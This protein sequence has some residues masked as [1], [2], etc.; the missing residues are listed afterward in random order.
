MQLMSVG[1]TTL[2]CDAFDESGKIIS[3]EHRRKRGSPPAP[4]ASAQR[5]R[6][7]VE[8]A[9]ERTRGVLW[10]NTNFRTMAGACSAEQNV[11]WGSPI[12]DTGV[13]IN[14]KSQA[15]I[16]VAK[17]WPAAKAH[18]I[19]QDELQRFMREVLRMLHD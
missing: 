12:S 11:I 3:T 14:G 16:L 7:P 18:G 2:S 4:R 9:A 19:S 1:F 15:E 5:N 10:R 17:Y 6:F 13:N 8:P